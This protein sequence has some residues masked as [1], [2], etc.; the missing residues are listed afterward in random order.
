M[1][2]RVTLTGRQRMQVAVRALVCE[3]SVLRY[4]QGHRL[5]ETTIIRIRQAISDL[6]IDPDGA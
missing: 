2:P 1:E 3:S 4:Q 6:K 5:R